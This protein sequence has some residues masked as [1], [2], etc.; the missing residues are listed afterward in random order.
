MRLITSTDIIS[1]QHFW[2]GGLETAG[3][4]CYDAV[5]IAR[6]AGFRMSVA[7]IQKNRCRTIQ[8]LGASASVVDILRGVKTVATFIKIG[9]LLEH[10]DTL[11]PLRWNPLTLKKAEAPDRRQRVAIK[12]RIGYNVAHIRRLDFD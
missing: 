12:P 3:P 2:T 7:G 11:N 4:G 6:T 5:A 8:E 1:A 10:C 9:E